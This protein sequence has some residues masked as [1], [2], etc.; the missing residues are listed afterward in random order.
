MAKKSFNM[1]MIGNI[2]QVSTNELDSYLKDS[3]LL[4]KRI[5]DN[6]SGDQNLTDIE[7]AWHGIVFLLTGKDWDE[8]NESLARI[9][10]S[11]QLIDEEQDFGYGPAHY[12]TPDQVINLNERISQVVIGD[13]KQRF[14]PKKMTELEIYPMIWDEG[15]DAF[16]YLS[17][18]FEILK[19]TY[20]E[21]AMKKN[22]IIT[23]L[24]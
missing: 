9:L 5:F 23:F 15:D 3:S 2:L 10:F 24:S 4:E 21:A 20:S 14:D 8:S 19:K 6:E 17:E 7:K 13:L 16:D 1:S 12:L 18:Y 11:G 22:A